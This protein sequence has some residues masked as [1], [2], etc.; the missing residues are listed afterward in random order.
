MKKNDLIL[1]TAVALYSLLFYGQAPGINFLVF[2]LALILLL[3]FRDRR[4]LKNKLWLSSVIA[5]FLSGA[6][7]AYSG[8]TLSVVANI[9]SLAALSAYSLSSDS[10]IFALLHSL[11]SYS[12]SLVFIL[13]DRFKSHPESETNASGS[14]RIR[15]FTLILIPLLIALVFFFMYRG[16]NVLFD[17]FAKKINFDFISLNWVAFT[18]GGFLLLYGFFHLRIISSFS[19][20]DQRTGNSLDPARK[21]TISLFGKHLSIEEQHFSGVTLFIM[22]NVLLLIVN[23]LDFHFLFIDSRLPG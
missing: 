7:V 6:C 21:T 15:K 9:L 2:S 11:Y 1:V 3:L 14:P 16:A 5:S 18:L 22:L 8:N 19:Q 20:Y 10:L 12:S 17:E 23:S 4:L 13:V